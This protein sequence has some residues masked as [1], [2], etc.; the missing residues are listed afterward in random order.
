MKL[1]KLFLTKTLTLELSFAKLELFK[2]NSD[3][4]IWIAQLVKKINMKQF[5]LKTKLDLKLTL[6][7]CTGALNSVLKETV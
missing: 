5:K 6:A 4:M 1:V 7:K 2:V 3:T